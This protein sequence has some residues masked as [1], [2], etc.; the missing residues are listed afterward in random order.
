MTNQT[1][2]LALA[3]LAALLGLVLLARRRRRRRAVAAVEA[4]IDRHLASLVRRRATLLVKD[5]YGVLTDRTRRRWL[6]EKDHFVRNVL[7]PSLP[8]AHHPLALA[9]GDARIEAAIETHLAGEGAEDDPPARNPIEYEHLCARLLERAG[10]QARTT[11]ASG[12]QGADVIADR[13][14]FRL[15]VQCKFYAKPVGNKAVQEVV[16]ARKFVGADFAAVVSPSG[17]TASAQELAAA[18]DVSLLHHDE[19]R[20]LTLR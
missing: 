14:G 13:D 11:E 12:D 6:K 7:L 3:G 2:V 1:W 20:T 4:V 15:V 17:F 10:W 16:A 18:N 9:E 19:L 5:D 8:E